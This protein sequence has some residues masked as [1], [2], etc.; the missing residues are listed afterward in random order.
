MGAAR[1]SRRSRWRCSGSGWRRAASR[2]TA[3]ALGLIIG[4]AI[5]N[6]IDRLAYGAV[7]DFVLLHSERQM[8]LQLVR[9]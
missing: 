7:A 6:A 3:L 2:L 8:A 5:G 1:R 4:G 9:L